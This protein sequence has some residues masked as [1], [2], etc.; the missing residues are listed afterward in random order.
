MNLVKS[1]YRNQIC[2]SVADVGVNYS[3]FNAGSLPDQVAQKFLL[4][5]QSLTHFGTHYHSDDWRQKEKNP[6]KEIDELWD[7]GNIKGKC[8]QNIE[9][10]KY[11][12][13]KFPWM[14][15]ELSIFEDGLLTDRISSLHVPDQEVFKLQCGPAPKI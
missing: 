11:R 9:P 6:Q 1:A 2:Y 3:H 12:T 7:S 14:W 10:I 15:V 5:L 4:A 13:R 8:L